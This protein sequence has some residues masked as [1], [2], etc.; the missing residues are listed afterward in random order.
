LYLFFFCCYLFST[1]TTHNFSFW[2][3]LYR[4]HLAWSGFEL[5]N[6]VVIGTDCIDSCRSNY[7]ANMTNTG[8]IVYLTLSSILKYFNV[9]YYYFYFSETF[10]NMWLKKVISQI[11]N[12]RDKCVDHWSK[13]R[14]YSSQQKMYV[15]FL[16]VWTKFDT[17]YFQIYCHHLLIKKY[18]VLYTIWLK[19][20]SLDIEQQSC[21]H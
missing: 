14:K 17:L 3:M 20:C 5:T 8:P 7:H 12:Y 10:R 19:N 1:F 15:H 21:R 9:H 18:F 11:I 2:T 13:K 6:L 16:A 4:V